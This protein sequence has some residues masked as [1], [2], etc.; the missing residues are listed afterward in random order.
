VPEETRDIAAKR[1]EA[2]DALE[3][4][5]RYYWRVRA[6]DSTGAKGPWAASTYIQAVKSKSKLL[7]GEQFHA[8]IKVPYNQG[9]PYLANFLKMAIERARKGK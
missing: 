4:N 8:E 5:S 2:N 7:Y 9:A 1:V 3:D 6:V